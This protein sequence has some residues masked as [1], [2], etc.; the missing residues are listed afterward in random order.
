MEFFARVRSVYLARAKS[1]PNRIQLIDASQ[2][3][4]QIREVLEKIITT[5]CNK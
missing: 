3:V 2:T 1:F 4:D 5:Y